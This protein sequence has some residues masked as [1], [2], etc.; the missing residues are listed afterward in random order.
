MK[1]GLKVFVIICVLILFLTG[2]IFFARMTLGREIDDVSPA[3]YCESELIVKSDVLWVIPLYENESISEDIGWCDYIKSLNKT[4]GMHGVEHSYREFGVLR[5]EEYIQRGIDA[6]E[7]CFGYT[8]RRFKAPQIDLNEGN[9]ELLEDM[10]FDV[11]GNI[12]QVMHKVYHCSDTGKLS[13]KF[14]EWF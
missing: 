11:K 10:G 2:Y 13:N 12:N 4:L 7:E 14:I 3:I 6:F 5:N 1:K 9:I 8:P